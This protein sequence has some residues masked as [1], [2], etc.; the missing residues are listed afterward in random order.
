MTE[1]AVFFKVA[2]TNLLGKALEESSFNNLHEAER[3]LLNASM[4]RKHTPSLVI[5]FDPEDLVMKAV[6][7]RADGVV[8]D[9]RRS[10]SLS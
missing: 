4:E 8:I 2:I 10:G 6:Y 1:R 9:G 5:L 7:I 3:Y